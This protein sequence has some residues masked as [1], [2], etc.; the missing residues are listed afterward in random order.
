MA[1]VIKMKR[2]KDCDAWEEFEVKWNLLI[3]EIAQP[4]QKSLDVLEIQWSRE[5]KLYSLA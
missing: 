2:E 3:L 4:L 1:L 5:L